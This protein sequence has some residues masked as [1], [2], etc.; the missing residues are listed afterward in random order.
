MGGRRGRSQWPISPHPPVSGGERAPSPPWHPLRHRRH[1]KLCQPGSETQVALLPIL[2]EYDH[3]HPP[4]A[5]GAK[6]EGGIWKRLPLAAFSRDLLFSPGLSAQLARALQAAGV[7]TPRTWPESET[8]ARFVGSTW[9]L[10]G[11]SMWGKETPVWWSGRITLPF[12]PVQGEPPA[13][14]L[15][16]VSLWTHQQSSGFW[17]AQESRVKT[18]ETEGKLQVSLGEILLSNKAF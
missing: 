12:G 13:W 15:C 2:V 10:L 11:S 1:S 16:P 18:R 4:S 8:E 17:S 3:P 9:S 5:S 6:E 14:H 7:R